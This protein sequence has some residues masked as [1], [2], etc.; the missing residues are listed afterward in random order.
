VYW[1]LIAIF[2]QFGTKQRASTTS[3]ARV[4]RQLFGARS[5]ATTM[6]RGAEKQ[7]SKDDGDDDEIEVCEIKCLYLL[8]YNAL[9]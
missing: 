8:I 1:A 7:L 4:S 5:S 2:K 9:K 6:K 3:A